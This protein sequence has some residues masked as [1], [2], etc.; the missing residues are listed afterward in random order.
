M[1]WMTMLA[2]LVLF[3]STAGLSQAKGAARDTVKFVT[4]PDISVPPGFSH[5]AIVT[6]GKLIFISGQVGLD[7]QGQIVG[8]D[9]FR[10][11]VNQAF[12]NLRAALAATGAKPEHLV[13]LTYYVVGLNRDRL[14]AIREV[15]NSF[16]NNVNPPTST[17]IGV[18][19]LFR[20]DAL[21][22]IEAVAV[23]P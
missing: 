13:K 16:V 15:R 20:E 14:A 17:L 8:K 5:A 18:A 23:I 10:A 19:A 21:I 22:E 9:D 1:K 7:Q 12:I 6:G 2:M 3:G 11:Q 4:S